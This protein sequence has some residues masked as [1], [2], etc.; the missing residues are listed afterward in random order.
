MSDESKR[1]AGF[2]VNQDEFFELLG[3]GKV[4]SGH[5]DEIGIKPINGEICVKV[6]GYDERMPIENEYPL[7]HVVCKTVSSHFEKIE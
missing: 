7:C 1:S 3:F 6:S 2:L 4:F 5:I